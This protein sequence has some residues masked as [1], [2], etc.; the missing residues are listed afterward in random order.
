MTP[1]ISS[2][3]AGQFDSGTS[4]VS[5]GS[6]VSTTSP[7]S[8]SPKVPGDA[9]SQAQPA[10]WWQVR[11]AAMQLLPQALPVVQ[12]RQQACPDDGADVA[13]GLGGGGGGG[14]AAAGGGGGGGAGAAAGGGGEGGGTAAGAAG[15]AV[16]PAA[17]QGNSGP[18]FGRLARPTGPLIQV[19]VPS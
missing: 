18:A 14:G 11:F 16:G 2:S 8:R 5:A 9:A 10:G 13:V 17:S 6:A 7:G 19:V 4:W 12:R 15:A 3:S 1:A